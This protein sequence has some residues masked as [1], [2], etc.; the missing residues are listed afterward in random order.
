MS[1]RAST[2]ILRTR[3]QTLQYLLAGTISSVFIGAAI[4]YPEF[5]GINGLLGYLFLVVLVGY[6]FVLASDHVRQSQYHPLI[7]AVFFLSWG[8]YNV[9]RGRVGLLTIILLV[10][11]GSALLWGGYQLAQKETPT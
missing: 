5:A 2:S 9:S 3:K 11:G 10:G 7:Q 1:E 6:L 4:L 8:G